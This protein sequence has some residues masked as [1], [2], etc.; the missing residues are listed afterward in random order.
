[1]SMEICNVQQWQNINVCAFNTSR[2]LTHTITISFRVTQCVHISNGWTRT[3][4]KSLSKNK[5]ITICLFFWPRQNAHFMLRLRR[6]QKFIV[7]KDLIGLQLVTVV[8][9][10]LMDCSRLY[11]H[12]AIDW[13]RRRMTNHRKTSIFQVINTH[14]LFS[15][16]GKSSRYERCAGEIFTIH[17]KCKIRTMLQV[18]RKTNLT[19]WSDSRFSEESPILLQIIPQKWSFSVVAAG[20]QVV[21]C[22][23]CTWPVHMYAFSTR[24]MFTVCRLLNLWCGEKKIVATKMHGN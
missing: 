18:I 21:H 7:L 3:T 11:L 12:V 23:Y 19:T 14:P 22:F 17:L 6:N 24:V 15:L 13:R 9:C 20:L 5:R 10:F 2:T 4:G 8:F 1:M 16:G